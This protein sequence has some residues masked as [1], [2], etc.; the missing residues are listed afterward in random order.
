ME[1]II[2]TAVHSF[3]DAIRDIL[4]KSDVKSYSH[5]EVMGTTDLSEASRDT[6]WFGTGTVE[7]SSIVFYAFIPH[8]FVSKVMTGI[9]E[10]NA[11]EL[12]R[13]HIHAAV[14]E[15]KDIV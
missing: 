15:V 9:K 7:Q 3:K 8:Q 5:T 12:S 1:L 10:L 2:I 13:S 14:M 6:N 4:K 11:A